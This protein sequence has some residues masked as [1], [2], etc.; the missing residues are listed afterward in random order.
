MSDSLV[1]IICDVY[2][3]GPFLR[4]ALDGFIM[5]QVDFPIEILVHDDASTDNSAEIIRDYE[6]KY[7]HLIKPIY[8]TENQYHKLT[9]NFHGPKENTLPFAKVMTTGQTR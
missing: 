1:S 4:N 8:E 9:F 7:P 3:H 5:Q 6:A 2:N